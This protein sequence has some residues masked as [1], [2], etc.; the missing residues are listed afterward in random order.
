MNEFLRSE[1]LCS[2]LQCFLLLFI[3]YHLYILVLWYFKRKSY[4]T[5]WQN[6][7]LAVPFLTTTT[8]AYALSGIFLFPVDD[9]VMQESGIAIANLIR[10]LFIGAWFFFVLIRYLVRLRTKIEGAF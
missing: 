2:V 10:S 6:N 9:P 3:V 5:L 1:L 4:L 7:K 8:I